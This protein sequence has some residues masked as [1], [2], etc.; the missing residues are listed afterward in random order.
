MSYK[1]QF[2]T[3]T[4][5]KSIIPPLFT[6]M[7]NFIYLFM[8]GFSSICF[9]SCC[10][11]SVP[12]Q[13][14]QKDI[15]AKINTTITHDVVLSVEGVWKL[16]KDIDL[17]GK[18]ALIPEGVTLGAGKGRIKNGTLIGC[19]TKIKSTAPLFQNVHIK[20]VWDVPVISTSLFDDLGYVNS[21]QDVI[22]LSNPNV[23]NHITIEDG[24]Y[25]VSAQSFQGALPLTSNTHLKI[26]GDIRLVPN[27]HKGCYIINVHKCDNVT[28]DGSGTLFGD[29]LTHKG[30][31]GQWGHGINIIASSNVM[32]D[33]MHIEACWGDC[34]Y[35]GD[36]S[37]NVKITGCFLNN[38]HRQGISVTSADGVRIS[39]CIITNVAGSNPQYA[40]DIE[41]NENENVDNIIIENVTS[42][43]CVGG[44]TMWHPDHA[45]IGSVTIR[46]CHITG[47][48]AKRPVVLELADKVVFK[49]CYVEVNDKVAISVTKVGNLEMTGNTLITTNITP[50]S[51]ALC[52]KTN[53]KNNYINNE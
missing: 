42:K 44:I 6:K 24:C 34:I 17:E 30:T 29:K 3:A 52:K 13:S 49:D 11:C 47:T 27:S 46:N 20:G 40:I 9:F 43:D 50:Y 41:P 23:K 39:N 4:C 19:N 31:E 48:T 2:N 8:V 7:A 26:N 16:D 25:Q 32:V 37:R 53:V 14:I 35:V 12:K 10:S 36:D 33:G 15:R 5:N 21:L 38:S 18:I 51:I 28:I 45:S 1:L 22:A